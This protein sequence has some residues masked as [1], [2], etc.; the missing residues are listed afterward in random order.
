MFYLHLLKKI[1]R[2]QLHYVSKSI[3][4]LTIIQ[5]HSVLVVAPM[6]SLVYDAKHSHDRPNFVACPSTIRRKAK[7]DNITVGL[8]YF[9][10]FLDIHLCCAVH[11]HLFL[12]E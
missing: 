6:V 3:Y 12:P 2:I 11:H 7:V 9:F 10:N 8:H 4:V 5:C 1:K